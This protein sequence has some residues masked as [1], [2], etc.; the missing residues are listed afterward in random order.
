VIRKLAP[1]LNPA[2]FTAGLGFIDAAVWIGLNLAAGLAAI[3][4]SLIVL[5][6]VIGE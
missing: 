4:V 2:L 5:E 3:G 6:V 1:Y